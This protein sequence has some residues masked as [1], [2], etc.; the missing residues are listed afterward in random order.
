MDG[1]TLDALLTPEFQGQL[2]GAASESAPAAT[3]AQGQGVQPPDSADPDGGQGD[4]ATPEEMIPLAQYKELQKAFTQKSMALS[5]LKKQ[6]ETPAMQEPVPVYNQAQAP[7]NPLDAIIESKIA[8]SFAEFVAPIQ[9]QQQDLRIQTKIL[10]L[11]E[12]KEFEDVA[13]DF[14]DLLDETPELIDL[15]NGLDLAFAAVRASYLERTATA[16]AQAAINSSQ[17]VK[18][19]KIAANDSTPLARQ[20]AAAGTAEDEAEAIRQSMLG[21]GKRSS[22][23]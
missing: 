21:L 8:A 23:F 5:Q 13:Q 15:P 22:I 20:A 10:E 12:H 9:Q 17:Q 7:R 19:Q 14:V 16:R 18:A 11:A 2:S 6:L 1:D 4:P 3:F